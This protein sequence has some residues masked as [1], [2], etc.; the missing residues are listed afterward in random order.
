MVAHTFNPSTQEAQTDGFLSSR[1]AWSTKRVPGQQGIYRETL[2]QKT[3]NKKN[4]TKQNKK[5][6]KTNKQKTTKK[7]LINIQ[8]SIFSTAH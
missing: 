5:K 6:N 7:M 8:R 2:S 3:K 4:K 1:L